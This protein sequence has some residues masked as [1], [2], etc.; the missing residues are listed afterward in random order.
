MYAWLVGWL[1]G[2]SILD[3]NQPC[4]LKIALV[5]AVTACLR[6]ME[7]RDL[8]EV[9]EDVIL[10]I[11]DLPGNLVVRIVDELD[12]LFDDQLQIPAEF[13]LSFNQLTN[14]GSTPQ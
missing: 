4:D 12:V 6:I 2:C 10:V 3:L 11:A 7:V 14:D 9:V 5:L 1:D 13:L 8:F